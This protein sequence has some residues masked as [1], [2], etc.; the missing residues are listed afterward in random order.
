MKNAKQ[1]K[2]FYHAK[3]HTTTT[4]HVKGSGDRKTRDKNAAKKYYY[5]NRP[6][7][8]EKSKLQL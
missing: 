3:T 4:S 2:N 1:K 7:I 5:S 6:Q 8:L